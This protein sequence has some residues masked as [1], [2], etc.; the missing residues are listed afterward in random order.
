MVNLNSLH[1]V[2]KHTDIWIWTEGAPDRKRIQGYLE[3]AYSAL[4][5]YIQENK[6]FVWSLHPVEFS[7]TAPDI[8][9][10]MCICAQEAE[11]GPMA[12]VAGAISDCLGQRLSEDYPYIICNNGGDIYYKTEK[13]QQFLISAQGSPFHNKILIDAPSAEKGRGLCTSSGI[14]G[15]SMN[16][17]RAF[18]VSIL[19][20][21]A[22]LADVWA[23]SISNKVTSHLTID[24]ALE[25][26]KSQ[27]G[28]KGVVILVDQYLGAWG[29]IKINLR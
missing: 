20:S 3:D 4:E 11:V 27:K 28:I 29:D 8:V 7:D 23:T 25:Y 26:C 9:K 10:H 5:Q 13:E 1:L 14:S 24:A 18:A 19:A 6:E 16:M 12:G 22:C 17:G 2:Y 15:H 21:D